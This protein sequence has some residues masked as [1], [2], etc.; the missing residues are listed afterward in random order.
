MN[1][2]RAFIPGVWSLWVGPR[3]KVLMWYQ[4]R[5]GREQGLKN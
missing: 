3:K 5:E 2:E 1:L 4:I